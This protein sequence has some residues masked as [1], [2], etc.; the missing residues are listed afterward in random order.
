MGLVC[1]YLN[2]LFRISLQDYEYSI[3][4]LCFVVLVVSIL[5]MINKC[6]NMKL[7]H[8]FDNLSGDIIDNN[9]IN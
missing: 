7:E 4:N 8:W 5:R 1:H 3:L 2:Y 6:S 9:N